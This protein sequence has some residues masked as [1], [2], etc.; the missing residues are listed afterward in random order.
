MRYV[1]AFATV[2]AMVSAQTAQRADP[3]PGSDGHAGRALS[4]PA[5]I[6][7]IL[8]SLTLVAFWPVAGA[9][10]IN[11]DDQDYVTANPQVQ[12][13]LNWKAAEWAFRTSHASNWHPV[14]WL[15]HMLDVSLFGH[16]PYGSTLHE[17]RAAHG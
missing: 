12:A 3:K 16:R 14:T 10:F 9:E 11:Y 2:I 15:S 5:I 8:A 1:D 6:S 7:L 4:N 13:G 17:S